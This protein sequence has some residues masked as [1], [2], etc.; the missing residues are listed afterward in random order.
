MEGMSR[1]NQGEYASVILSPLH[2]MEIE[3]DEIVLESR[4]EHLM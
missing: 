4:P 3:P 1:L 2:I